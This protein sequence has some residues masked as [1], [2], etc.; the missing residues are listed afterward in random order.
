MARLVTNI[1]TEAAR[2]FV[3]GSLLGLFYSQHAIYRHIA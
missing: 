2:A 3:P 1:T